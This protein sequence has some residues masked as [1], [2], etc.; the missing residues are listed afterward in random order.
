MTPTQHSIVAL[1]QTG[2]A[3]IAFGFAL[4]LVLVAI[5][6]VRA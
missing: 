2:L 6:K 3:V 4:E 1:G 5:G